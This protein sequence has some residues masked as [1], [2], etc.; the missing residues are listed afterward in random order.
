LAI[1]YP[2]DPAKVIPDWRWLKQWWPSRR[3]GIDPLRDV[4]VEDRYAPVSI[5]NW[6]LIPPVARAL[7]SRRRTVPL[8][9]ASDKRLTVVIPFRDRQ[10]HLEQLLPRL[11]GTLDEQG[12][13]YRILVV[14]QLN[15]GAFNRGRLLNAGMQFA[16]ETSDYYCLHDVDAVPLNANYRCPSQPL[17]LVH[18][19]VGPDGA[20][21]RPAHY[22]SGA[23]S[24]RTEQVF[25]ANGYS[26][27][28]WGWGKE[29]DDLF[30]RL[31]MAGFLCYFDLRGEYEDLPNPRHQQVRR[32][33]TA[34]RRQVALNRQRRSR[35]QRG[36]EQPQVDGLSTLRHEV[37]RSST[38]E[39]YEKIAVRW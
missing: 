4:K 15:E 34:T 3:V 12:I 10:E 27:E 22:F 21:F 28:Y 36:L 18:R 16:K 9:F 31:L 38:E 29:D 17:R 2:F 35:L 19:I 37:V 24:I 20:S 23:I 5:A 32:D 14:E 6:K 30:F 13:A 8:T 11:A 1:E 25:A 33:N 7:I 39:G 26:N